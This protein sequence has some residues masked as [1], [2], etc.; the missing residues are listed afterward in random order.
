MGAMGAMSAMYSAVGIAAGRGHTHVAKGGAGVEHRKAWRCA[1]RWWM[2]GTSKGKVR[3]Q[4]ENG[5]LR[6]RFVLRGG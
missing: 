6:W 1:G 5:N 3:K 2:G 4:G